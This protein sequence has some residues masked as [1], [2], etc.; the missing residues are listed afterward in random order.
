MKKKKII[1]Y[2]PSMKRSGGTEAVA[3]RLADALSTSCDITIL[4]REPTTKSFFSTS[5]SVIFDSLNIEN[6]LTVKQAGIFF[7]RCIRRLRRYVQ[8]HPTDVILCFCTYQALVAYF[9]TLHLP[10]K[11]IAFEHQ[12]FF[13]YKEFSTGMRRSN[14]YLRRFIYPRLYSVVVLTQRDRKEY[15]KFSHNVTVIPNFVKNISADIHIN[16]SNQNVLALGRVSKQKGFDLLM[17]AWAKLQP[18]FTSWHLIVAGAVE[19]EKMLQSMQEYLIEHGLNNTVTFA[20]RLSDQG[21]VEVFSNSSV[22]VLPSRFEALPA[23]LQEAM[24]YGLPAVS[25]DCK[26]GP[27][28]LIEDGKDGFLAKPE[29]V[30]ELSKKMAVLMGNCEQR[31]KMGQAAREKIL[32]VF[33]RENLLDMWRKLF[34]TC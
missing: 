28:E 12:N 20:G 21:I 7:I 16:Y 10:V 13:M 5:E 25:F 30:D 1:F 17:Q 33:D 23:V 29:D 27:S 8:E 19:D 15:E 6:P 4:N 18:E 32:T 22:F 24:A 31:K 3:A 2:I 34:E 11:V 9:S 14:M 26:T